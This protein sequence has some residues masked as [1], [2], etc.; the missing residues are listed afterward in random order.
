M[1]S[2]GSWDTEDWSNDPENS[3]LITAINDILKY[4]TIENS[5]FQLQYYFTI[6]QFYCIFNQINAALVSIKDFFQKH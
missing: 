6:L 2:E 4:I 1:I 5:Y 3:A